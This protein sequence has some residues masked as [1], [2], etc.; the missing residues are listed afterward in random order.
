VADGWSRVSFVE[1]VW[2][3]ANALRAWGSFANTR[4]E[5]SFVP[6]VGFMFVRM[7]A[8]SEVFVHEQKS[9]FRMTLRVMLEGAMVEQLY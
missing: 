4:L 3:V 1:R 6:G 2:I 7:E 5:R 9:A 8:V